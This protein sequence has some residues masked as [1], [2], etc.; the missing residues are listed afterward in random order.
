MLF[1][2]ERVLVHD[3]DRHVF[4]T[5]RITGGISR[6]CVIHYQHPKILY[7]SHSS[8]KKGIALIPNPTKLMH[9]EELSII[10]ESLRNQDF[11][12]LHTVYIGGG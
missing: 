9:T 10:S 2:A 6:M 12:S 8:H 1:G 7:E 3:P 11:F 5:V 4:S